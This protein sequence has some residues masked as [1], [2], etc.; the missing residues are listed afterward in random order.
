MRPTTAPVRPPEDT[1]PRLTP[2]MAVLEDVATA[3]VRGRAGL[4]GRSA[5]VVLHPDRL[6]VEGPCGTAAPA[7]LLAAGGLVLDLRAALAA[8]GWAATVDRLPS[9]PGG[10]LAVLHPAPGLPDPDL[11]ALPPVAPA[12]EPGGDDVPAGVVARLAAAA[13]AEGAPVVSVGRRPPVLVLDWRTDDA[14]AWLRTGEALQRVARTAVALG[15]TAVPSPPAGGRARTAVRLGRRQG[16]PAP[17][18]APPAT[19]R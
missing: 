10:P 13:A 18:G 11:A 9:G 1:G 19:A 4:P 6:E 17:P 8:A 12:G 5:C 7:S 3:V 14:A 15:C 16:H 2:L